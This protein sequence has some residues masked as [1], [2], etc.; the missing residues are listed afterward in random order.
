MKKK[1]KPILTAEEIEFQN[2]RLLE[3]IQKSNTGTVRELIK[4]GVDVNSSDEYGLK[5]LMH[6]I[7]LNTKEIGSNR[8]IIN[9]LIKAGADVNARITD[10]NS[11][12]NVLTIAAGSGTLAKV[13][14]LL[15][16]GAEVL[17]DASG[18]TVLMEA[19][20]NAGAD[21]AKILKLFLKLGENVNAK[22][23]KG[24]TALIYAAINGCLEAAE[25]LI[26][27]GA[28]VN[29]KDCD[30]K[31]ALDYAISS[32]DNSVVEFLKKNRQY[33]LSNPIIKQST[34]YSF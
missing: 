3:A 24:E 19:A 7:A 9:Y 28:D 30:G 22:S 2:I 12:A 14:T 27:A 4:D 13:K 29:V 16:A 6:A 8:I 21:C 34:E 32:G 18:C 5:P 20:S 33:L 10:V 25:I 1:L 31:T 17:V 11:D 23:N 15:D 26:N